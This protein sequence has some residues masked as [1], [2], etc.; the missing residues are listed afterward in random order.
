MS[1]SRQHLGQNG[2]EIAAALLG[3]NGYRIL[4][5]N[6]RCKCGEIDII[7]KQGDTLVFLEVKTRTGMAYGSPSAAVTLKKQRQ[8]SRTAQ[9]YLAVHNLFDAPARFDVVSVIITPHQLP[10]IEI[11]ANAFDL[12]E[13]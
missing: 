13:D 7:A 10:R 3:E 2:E 6:Y 11:I 12:C 8:I 9:Y 4:A 5:R 1:N